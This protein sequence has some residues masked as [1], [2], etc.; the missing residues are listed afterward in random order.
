MKRILWLV[1]ALSLGLVLH[2]QNPVSIAQVGVTPVTTT[3]PVSGTVAATQSGVWAVSFSSPQSVTQGTSPWVISFTSPQ[4]VTQ[5]GTW[6]ISFTA[7][8]H[9]IIDSGT[10]DVTNAGTFAVQVSSALPAGSNVIG[11]VIGDTGSTTAVTGN[12][13]VVQPTGTNLHAVLDTTSTTAVTQATG[14]NLHAVLDTTSTTAV[15]Q[16]TATNLNAAVVGT[17]TAGSA[18]GGVLTVQGVASM[19]KLLVTPDSVALPANQ[20]VNMAQIGGTAVI[21]DPCEANAK[22]YTAISQSTGTQLITGT[23]AKKIYYCSVMIVVADAEN[24]S[25]VSGTGTVCA[26]NTVA[27]I[28]GTSAANGPNLAAGGGFALGNGASSIAATTVNADNVCLLQSG[29][30]RIAGVLVTVVQ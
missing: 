4:A 6:S 25:F 26:T 20:S 13:T 11:H 19:T 24:I 29:S 28:G 17:G 14:T 21:A 2:A 30:G 23:S 27:N 10:T 7:P 22:V 8:Q 12:V 18:A 9:V 1:L 15:T 3:V 5:S 16:A